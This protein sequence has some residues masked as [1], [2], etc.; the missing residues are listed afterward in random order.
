ME[1]YSAI[2]LEDVTNKKND[3]FLILLLAFVL[4][5]SNIWGYDLWSPDEPRF[6]EVA[7][8]M[9]EGK[10]WILPHNNGW[11]Y[12]DKPP[13]FF[14]L[15][16]LVSM[17]LGG[18]SSFSARIPSVLAGIGTVYLTY[19]ITLR[20]LG[21]R[22]AYLS[23]IILTTSYLF[24]EKA[25]TAQTDMVLTFLIVL[26]FLLFYLSQGERLS[27]RKYLLL[28]YLT[29]A[30]ATLTKGPVGFIIPLGVILVYFASIGE[31]RKIKEIFIWDGMILF[32][33]IVVGWIVA[34]TIVGQGEYNIISAINRH[35]VSRFAEGLHHHRPFYYFFKSFPLDFLPWTFFIPSAFVLAF[36]KLRS[37]ERKEMAFSLC[38][39]FFV[40]V[41]FSFSREK[42]S[43][44]LLPLFPAASIMVAHLLRS[45]FAGQEEM[46]K[47]FS[48]MINYFL[49][50]CVFISG[51]FL[52]VMAF[53]KAKDYLFASFVLAFVIMA[54]SVAIF[55]I[56]LKRG[57]FHGLSLVYFPFLFALGVS[58]PML[59]LMKN[60]D[61]LIPTL[62][63]GIVLVLGS[64][65][66][67]IEILRNSTFRI[68]L[69]LTLTICSFYLTTVFFAYPVLN[70]YKSAKDFSLCISSTVRPYL[71][72]RERLP[73]YRTYRS[74]YTFYSGLYL[75]VIS[76]EGELEQLLKEER[77]RFCLIYENNL[78]EIIGKL[79]R[80]VY[81][82]HSERIG[83]RSMI[84]ISNQP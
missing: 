81:K 46:P 40:F 33:L 54:S 27:R 65:F 84:L 11:I 20:S 42:R 25:R 1:S 48:S 51:F 16:S 77:R 35:A 4:F 15:V 56:T 14:W 3:L 61:F 2:V 57:W 17:M 5:F 8:E 38:W 37:A 68:F 10:N 39:F 74:S 70:E 75:E 21:R 83:H 67:F 82:L 69:V 23:S 79:E 55:I 49:S 41:F 45:V 24:F 50:G 62:L 60:Q 36:S 34:A 22:T 12:T 29:L 52:P 71:E 9:I 31:F 7:K 78:K 28:F 72:Q 43:L 59:S 63:M 58:L 64:I 18:V 13:F 53:M 19:M 66:L 32:L 30:L 26:S 80:P 76:S 73:I 44:Y 47:R 6:A